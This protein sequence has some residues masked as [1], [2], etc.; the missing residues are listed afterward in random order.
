MG[1]ADL[2]RTLCLMRSR[3]VIISKRQLIRDFEVNT[4]SHAVM[5][6]IACVMLHKTYTSFCPQ[7]QCKP[8]YF[9][10][11]NDTASRVGIP[12]NMNTAKQ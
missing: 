1:L 7:M 10:Q 2:Q 8:S 4:S 11:E 6:G 9:L 5:I 3:C 12:L